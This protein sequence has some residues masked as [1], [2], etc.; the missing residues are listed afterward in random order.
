MAAGQA[1]TGE[2]QLALFKDYLAEPRFRIKLDEMVNTSVRTAL[3]LMA[4]DKFSPNGGIKDVAARLKAYEDMV[5][6][7]QANAVLLGRWATT[8]QQP[9]LSNIMT[10]MA[11]DC[12]GKAQSGIT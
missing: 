12:A 1:A 8:E 9:T 7:L 2:D 11:D 3:G 6:P 4:D 5:R 10:R